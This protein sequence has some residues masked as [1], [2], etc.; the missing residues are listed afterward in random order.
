[1]WGSVCQVDLYLY[2][3]KM[4]VKVNLLLQSVGPMGYSSASHSLVYLCSLSPILQLTFM[5]HPGMQKVF[6]KQ[7]HT[8]DPA[9]KEEGVQTCPGICRAPAVFAWATAVKCHRL[10]SS[11]TEF[12]SL[13]CR[14]GSPRSRYGRIWFLAK[15]LLLAC[16]ELPVC[17]VLAQRPASEQGVRCVFLK[18]H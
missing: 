12:I 4:W 9:L 14:L 5:G 10:G 2:P 16:R 6:C 3:E 17:C 8:V 15:S 1:M 7:R 13:F 11:T 18:G